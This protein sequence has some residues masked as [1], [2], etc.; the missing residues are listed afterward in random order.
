MLIVGKSDGLFLFEMVGSSV[1]GA[2]VGICV[3]L[4]DEKCMV[5][6][7]DG[8]DVFLKVSSVR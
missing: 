3:C 4:C 6:L 5:G 8:M 7:L 2:I 1:V